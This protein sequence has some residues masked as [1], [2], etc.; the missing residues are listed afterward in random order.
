MARGRN[1]NKLTKLKKI[2]PAVQTLSLFFSVPAATTVQQ[3]LD[4]SQCASLV[5]RRF[6]R[7]GLIWAV[8]RIKILS[9]SVTNPLGV[10]TVTKLPDTWVMSN[11]W[12]KGYSAWRKMNDEAL[13]E[14]ESVR[15]RF[16]DFKIYADA[17]HHQA[18]F[19]GNLLPN[20]IAGPYNVGEWDSSKI[21]QPVTG[22]AVVDPGEVYEREIMA[23]GANYPGVSPV[24]GFNSVSLI[25]GYA[26][27]RALPAITDPNTPTDS[28]DTDGATP[29]NWLGSLFNDGTQQSSELIEI[30]R[31][32]N[33]QAPYPFENDGVNPDT[34]Y[35]GGQN[36]GTGLQIHD[37]EF[38]TGTTVGGHSNIKGGLF[39]C[40]LIRFQAQNLDE[41][42]SL[43]LSIVIDLVPGAHRGYLAEPMQDM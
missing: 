41:V 23:V 34:M 35:P 17:E 9:S 38:I 16:E 12:H 30:L 29:E 24:S 8:G 36:Q 18:G 19:A 37:V 26:N 4:L 31:T 20:G 5:N 11:S 32:E 10:V 40:G 25:E 1:N 13:Q 28:Q 6:Y 7:Q 14:T 33:N 2:E 3:T 21:V 22:P 39:P 15:A 42:E 43:G 27:S